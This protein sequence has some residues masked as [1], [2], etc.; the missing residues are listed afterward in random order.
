MGDK[1]PKQ[2]TKR[3]QQKKME[4]IRKAQRG[5]PAPAPSQPEPMPDKR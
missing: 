5:R 1:S 2:K 3:D 4:K